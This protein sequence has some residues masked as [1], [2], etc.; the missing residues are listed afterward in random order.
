MPSDEKADHRSQAEKFADLARELECDQSGKKFEAAF[1]KIVPP[2]R[3]EKSS[4][5]PAES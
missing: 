3:G 4:D 1:G 5:G 2:K